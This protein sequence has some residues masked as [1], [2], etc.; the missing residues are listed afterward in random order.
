MTYFGRGSQVSPGKEVATLLDLNPILIEGYISE[1]NYGRFKVGE[2]TT[3]MLFGNKEYKGK[4]HFIS[5]IS[6]P[7]THMFM[8][9]VIMEKSRPIYS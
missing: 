4:I 8:V 2:E 3:I 1:K 9:E 5:S 7:K 6:D